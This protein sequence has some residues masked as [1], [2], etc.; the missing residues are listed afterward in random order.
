VRADP[1]L[2]GFFISTKKPG[3]LDHHEEQSRVL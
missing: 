3:Q 1:R 2:L